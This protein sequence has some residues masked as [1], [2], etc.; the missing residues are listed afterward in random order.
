M[1]LIQAISM[2]SA[3]APR[4]NRRALNVTRMTPGP[5]VATSLDALKAIRVLR[6]RQL[7]MS[8]NESD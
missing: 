5:N 8:Y 6:I 3:N 1:Y 2:R 4:A 7:A